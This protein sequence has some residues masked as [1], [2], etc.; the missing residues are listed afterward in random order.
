MAPAPDETHLVSDGAGV[1]HESSAGG[2]PT[3]S[4][5]L[6]ANSTF[7]PYRVIRELGRG[8]MGEVYEAEEIDTGRRVALKLLSRA[9]GDRQATD[10]FLREGRLAAAVSHP[11]SVYVF[12]SHEIDG[13]PAIAMEL[14][15]G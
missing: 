2:P 9:L 6:I 10:R 13:M 11:N 3:G 8:G 4:S 14:V 5:R 15:A 12:G 7:G 1:T